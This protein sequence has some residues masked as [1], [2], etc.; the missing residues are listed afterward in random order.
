MALATTAGGGTTTGGIEP[1]V[2]LDFFV[3]VSDFFAADSFI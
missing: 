2:F 1:D 3:H